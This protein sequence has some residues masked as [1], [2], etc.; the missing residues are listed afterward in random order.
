MIVPNIDTV[1]TALTALMALFATF[2]QIAQSNKQG[3]F[4]HRLS[5]WSNVKSLMNLC[6]INRMYLER[7]QEGPDLANCLSFQFMTN[8][9]YLYSIGPSIAHTLEHDYQQHLLC[10][11]AELQDLALEARF[12]FKG[13]LAGSL[14]MF[15]DSY[16][17]LLFSMY[18]YQIVLDRVGKIGEE[19]RKSLGDACELAEEPESRE[20]L[21]NERRALLE[22]YDRLVDKK[23]EKKVEKQCRLR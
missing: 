12:V 15:I 8:N 23:V 4:D 16:R 14:T 5:V 21:S 2:Y 11:L 20:K 10:K 7:G 18:Q 1:V 19:Q 17:S 22:S 6:E 13:G 9:V 3:L